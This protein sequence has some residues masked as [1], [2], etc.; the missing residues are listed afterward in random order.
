MFIQL[1]FVKMDYYCIYFRKICHW[2]DFFCM[3]KMFE[4]LPFELISKQY[5]KIF[6]SFQSYPILDGMPNNKTW[7]QQKNH[8]KRI[9]NISK[10]ISTFNFTKKTIL[11]TTCTRSIYNFVNFFSLYPRWCG[12]FSSSHRSTFFS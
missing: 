7:I 12:I 2:K 9:R 6:W 3:E 4:F 8:L 11:I 5:H 10:D 1:F